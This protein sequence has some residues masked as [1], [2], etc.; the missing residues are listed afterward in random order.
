MIGASRAGEIRTRAHRMLAASWR[1]GHLA[2]GTKFGYTCPS[3]FRYRH[4][5]YWDSCF[6][7]IVWRHFDAARAREELRTLVRAGR[8]DGLIPHT[9][10]WH[11]RAG[12]RRAPFYA[13]QS[14]RGSQATAHIQTPMI[15]LA[16]ER[17]ALA[18]DD[19]PGFRTEALDALRLHYDWLAEHRDPDGDGLISI[20]HP[21]ES[22]LDDSPKYDPVFGW[23]SHYLPGYF[24]LVERSRRLGYDSREIIER[25]DEHIEDVLVNVMYA[26]SLAALGRLAGEGEDGEYSGRA[27]KVEEAL[28]ERCWDERR[29]LFWDLAG[30][31]QRPIRISTWSSLAPLALPS[32]PEEVARRLVEEH[33]LD[34]RRYLAPVGIPS[35]SME[36]PSFRP[37]FH[38]FR[39]WRGPAWVN[40]AWLLV[41]RMRELGYTE[42]A[43]RVVE[44]LAGAVERHGFREYYNPL[45]GDGLAARRFG[46]S[47]LLVDLLENGAASVAGAAPPAAAYAPGALPS[48]GERSVEIEAPPKVVWEAL[49]AVLP[50]ALSAP[51][52]TPLARLLGSD[53]DS[54]TGAAGAEGSTLPGFEVLR[55]EPPVLLALAGQHHF[56]RYELLF[57]V[58]ELGRGRSRLIA[59][60]FGLFPRAHGRAFRALT[61]TSGAGTVALAVLLAAVRRRVERG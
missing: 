58:E 54:R 21:D 10:F 23:M 16:W 61:V 60:S 53:A 55:S 20:I 26:L 12:W 47:T 43:G 40:T 6:H 44:S 3:P 50:K 17:V 19:D 46:W 1:E 37:G 8:L 35:V 18:S 15:A 14:L 59:E 9:V 4:Q 48:V 29:G 7:A 52:A 27:R 28:L 2:D 22:G 36:E 11:E 33:L 25:Y 45:D 32:L 57:R 13:T 30:R 42:E 34:R 31:G 39:C 41:P 51:G 38:L 24:W 5:W 49:L 56:A